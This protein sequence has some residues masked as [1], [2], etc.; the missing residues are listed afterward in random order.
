MKLLNYHGYPK[1]NINESSKHLESAASCQLTCPLLD[2]NL[3]STHRDERNIGILCAMVAISP[4]LR[5]GWVW[6][7]H[8]KLR[9]TASSYSRIIVFF[10]LQ[11]TTSVCIDCRESLIDSPGSLMLRLALCAP[12][13]HK[14]AFSYSY[15]SIDSLAVALIKPPVYN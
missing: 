15:N 6:V 2:W 1:E 8:V 7:C 13:T 9:I 11:T 14:N 5:E 10:F 3:I 12:Q 4:S